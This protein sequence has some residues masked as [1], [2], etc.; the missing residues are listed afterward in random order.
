MISL[1]S[2]PRSAK[3]DRAASTSDTTSCRPLI[4]PGAASNRPTEI[5]IEQPEPRGVSCTTRISS[6]NLVSWSTLKPTCSL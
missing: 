2:T 5:T 4:E 6:D 1:T 3:P